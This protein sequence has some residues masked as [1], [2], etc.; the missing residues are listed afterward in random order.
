MVV[1]QQD[2]HDGV[3]R[4]SG[5]IGANHF[6]HLGSTVLAEYQDGGQHL[7]NGLDTKTVLR[8]TQLDDFSVHQTDTDP[9]QFGINICQIRD[10]VGVLTVC[11]VLVQIVSLLG[12]I[13]YLLD[14]YSSFHKL[15]NIKS[16]NFSPNLLLREKNAGNSHVFHCI[17][18]LNFK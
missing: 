7:G 17:T 3:E 11:I 2:G 16:R 5:S 1:F 13:L 10:V 8:V 15:K 6:E 18:N 12:N 14:S 4:Q 9:E